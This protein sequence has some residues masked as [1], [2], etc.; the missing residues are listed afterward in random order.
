MPIL[1]GVYRKRLCLDCVDDLEH[2]GFMTNPE[3]DTLQRGVCERCGRCKSVTKIYRYTLSS[4]ERA[5][6]RMD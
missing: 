4:R 6:R 5:R 1:K 3:K 2:E